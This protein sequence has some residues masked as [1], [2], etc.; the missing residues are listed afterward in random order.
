MGIERDELTSIAGEIR[1]YFNSDEEDIDI[2]ATIHGQEQDMFKQR[3]IDHMRDV[4]GLVRGVYLW[5]W[6]TLGYVLGYGI[7]YLL[8]LRRS[9]FPPLAK[10]LLWGGALTL[11]AV[12]VLG[13]A[14]LVAFD[15]LFRG[16]HELGFSNDLWRLNPREHNLIAMFPQGF[17]LRATLLVALLIIGQALLLIVVAGGCLWWR[18]RRS[19]AEEGEPLLESTAPLP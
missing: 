5:Q 7:A 15:A 13:L 9:A 11:I 8:L 10:R 6:I 14:S 3:E 17:F 2:R 12:V 19:K 18:R 16:F 4:K 1:D